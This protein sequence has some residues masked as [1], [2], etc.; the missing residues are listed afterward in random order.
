LTLT[1]PALLKG[2]RLFVVVPG[3]RKAEA[4]Y[5]TLSSPVSEQYPATILRTHPAV[6][7]FL[8]KDSYKMI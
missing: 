1:V 2:R 3:E 5:H 7:L 8:D 4:V 6:R